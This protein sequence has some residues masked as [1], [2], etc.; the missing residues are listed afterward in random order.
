MCVINSYFTIQNI[1]VDHNGIG[2]QTGDR[3]GVRWYQ[4]D[5]TGDSTGNAGNIETA[6]TIP[7]LVQAG[8]LYDTAITNPVSYY[9]PAIMSNSQGDISVSGLLSGLTQAISAFNVGKLGTDPKDGTLR[10]GASFA[11]QIIAQGSGPYTQTIG[12]DEFGVGFQFGQR[13]SDWTYTAYDPVDDLTMWN[14]SQYIQNGVLVSAF[15]RLD[16][17]TI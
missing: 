5:L 16:A 13:T 10:I 12:Q 4:I 6:T 14:I 9:N 17:P 3:W 7:A 8:T 2:S 15:S 1:I 11:D